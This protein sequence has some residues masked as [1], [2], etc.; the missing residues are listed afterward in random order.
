[1]ETALIT[2][3]RPNPSRSSFFLGAKLKSNWAL[4]LLLVIAGSY[5]LA[6]IF[7][8]TLPVSENGVATRYYTL[9]DDAMISMRY[10][11]NLS[12]G[13]GL[14]WN[15]GEYV[16]GYTNPLTVLMMT[17]VTF[18]FNKSMSVLVVQ[19]L[20]IFILAAIG[21]FSV[22]ITLNVVKG[23]N[24][25]EQ[26]LLKLIGLGAALGYFPIFYWSLLGMETGLLTLLELA[27][28]WGVFRF[29]E[30]PSKAKS[31]LTGL[32][33]GLAFLA[34]PD[35]L[36]MTAPILLYLV[37]ETYRLENSSKSQK[38][39][40]LAL[41]FGII[42]AIIAAQELFRLFYYG[43]LV[44]N[45]YTLKATGMPLKDKILNGIGF[46]GPFILET[47]P[48]LLLAA[49]GLILNFNRKC[50]LFY[51]IMVAL[52]GYQIYVGG[53]AWNYWRILCPAIPLLFV[54][55]A[56]LF[57]GKLRVRPL[58]ST[59]GLLV[60]LLAINARFLPEMTLTQEINSL[61]YSLREYTKIEVLNEVC[62]PDATIG[63]ITAGAIPY[64][65]GLKGIDFLGKMD[66]HIAQ[67]P[68]DLSGAMAK[69]GTYSLSGHNKYDLN[70]SIKEFKPDFVEQ[71]AWGAQDIW[72]WGKQYYEEVTI[73]NFTFYF[74]KDSPRIKWDVVASLQSET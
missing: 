48:V 23:K 18:F 5:Y 3:P 13:A 53:D 45:T 14:V 64:Y 67:L 12:H 55:I 50:L 4:I 66:K 40:Y 21:F 35:S 61:H 47:W 51:G 44:P 58:V 68:A 72:D 9:F 31:G 27:G 20:N 43:D 16:E 11:W 42:F 22:Q 10:A 70:Y 7:R 17:G 74:L 32:L 1:M 30:S 15:P 49:L 37:Y 6:F 46:I 24:K 71:F 73:K 65:T 54:I 63:M 60:L 8:T 39:Q 41:T 29:L 26:T 36:V 28:I 56:N 19:L 2:L 25:T 57:F 69:I 52:I 33:L 34:R 62:Y 38:L 59:L